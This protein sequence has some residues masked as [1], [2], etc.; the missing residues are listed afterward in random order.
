MI[1]LKDI[2]IGFQK[3]KLTSH[4][5]PAKSPCIESLSLD[6]NDT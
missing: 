6:D 5:Q 1:F 2:V 3:L 4:V